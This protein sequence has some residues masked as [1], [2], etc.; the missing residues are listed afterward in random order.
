[1]GCK[2]VCE[3]TISHTKAMIGTYSTTICIS[4][5][6]YEIGIVH[7][8]ET[9]FFNST[10]GSISRTVSEVTLV[11]ISRPNVNCYTFATPK[12]IKNNAPKNTKTG[13]IYAKSRDNSSGVFEEVS[14]AIQNAFDINACCIYYSSL[15]EKYGNK[16]AE[17]GIYNEEALKSYLS[18]HNKGF[19]L[20]S[21][22]IS[23]SYNAADIS[24]E[25]TETFK[26]HP[27]GLSLSQLHDILWYIPTDKLKDIVRR[28]DELVLCDTDTY[29]Y[30][31]YLPI[32]EKEMALRR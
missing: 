9:N 15:I 11:Y 17:I 7:G 29:M 25:I 13:R 6:V 3:S 1:M 4:R 30:A 10:S 23:K 24:G 26:D 5:T 28:T 14:E 21:E 2:V 18:G 8:S 19:V 27:K 31:P 12:T 32:G 16:L 22:Y 20:H